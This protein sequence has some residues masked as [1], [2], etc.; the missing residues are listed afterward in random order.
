[1]RHV[2]HDKHIFSPI[3]KIALDASDVVRS[4]DAAERAKWIFGFGG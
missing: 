2:S 3:D 4:P 1:M